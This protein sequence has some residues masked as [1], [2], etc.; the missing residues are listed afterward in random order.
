MLPSDGNSDYR[1]STIRKFRIVRREGMREVAR[2]IEHYSLPAIMRLRHLN[3]LPLIVA[4]IALCGFAS[5]ARADSPT[6]PFSFTKPSPDGRFLFVMIPRS[7][8]DNE[9][10]HWNEETKAKI[11]AIR[12]TYTQSGLYRNDG[13]STPLW[14]VDWYAYD[15]DVA[16]DGIHLVRHGPWASCVDQE[17]FSFLA[18]GKLVRTYAVSELIDLKFLLPHSV[19]HFQWSHG[20]RLDD[21]A[22]RY[23]VSTKD[24][25]S[26]VFD[27]TDGS[28]V[29][30]TRYARIMKW[31][32][33][34]AIPIVI[35][36]LIVL[37]SRRR[38]G[39]PAA[40]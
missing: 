19:S 11:R 34:A 29:Q 7:T 10:P 31:T 37:A 21:A 8:L 33:F 17:A 25:N 40:A 26:F 9:M 5:T 13:T 35:V 23:A 36:G 1:T 3:I 18:N 12:Q 27:I 4:T 30:E 28:I 14:T 22:L 6:P 15:V 38:Q 2:E 39:H 32:G 16:S 20:S 24:G